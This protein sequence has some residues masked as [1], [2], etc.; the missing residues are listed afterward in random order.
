MLSFIEK[1]TKKYAKKVAK[2]QQRTTYFA[3][4]L[5]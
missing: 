4:A 1:T 2:G 3:H 5:R